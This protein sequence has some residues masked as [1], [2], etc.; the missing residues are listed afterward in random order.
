MTLRPST[1]SPAAQRAH[2][3]LVDV[4][5]VVF[6]GSQV[7]CEATYERLL[8]VGRRCF[9][10][11]PWERLARLFD[12]IAHAISTG[13]PAESAR[14]RYCWARLEEAEREWRDRL[15]RGAAA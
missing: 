14:A 7:I 4:A 9:P 12:H 1:P 2:E 6:P 15:A 10:G 8:A 5:G 13:T 3:E 11:D